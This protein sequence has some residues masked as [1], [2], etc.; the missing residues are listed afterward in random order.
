MYFKQ[1]EAMLSK[2]QNKYGL[3]VLHLEHC[4]RAILTGNNDLFLSSLAKAK[5]ISDEWNYIDLLARISRLK[6]ECELHQYV[7]HSSEEQGRNI[8]EVVAREFETSLRLAL[9]YNRYL[10]DETMRTIGKVIIQYTG[11]SC[12]TDGNFLLNQIKNWWASGRL[13]SGQLLTASEAG[14][15][16]LEIGNG[17]PQMPL[18]KQIEALQASLQE[19]D[20]NAT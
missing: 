5:E 15:R 4:R 13:D 6:G 20:H 16:N 3:A 9:S 12:P 7:T 2:S 18:L 14:N 1:S 17:E 8:L 10:L 11:T 19:G